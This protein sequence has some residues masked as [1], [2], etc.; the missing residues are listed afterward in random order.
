MKPSIMISRGTAVFVMGVSGVGKSTFA[1]RLAL[2]L[3]M[4]F[5]E[6]DRLHPA[7]NVRK[8]AAGIAL[9]DE[10]RWPW[11]DALAATVTAVRCQDGVVATCSAL[12]RSYRDR[13]RKVV[14]PP[15]LFVCLTADPVTLSE[16]LRLREH[17]FMSS[18]LLESQLNA[19][20]LPGSDEN[21]VVI[22]AEQSIE[23]MLET[24][25]ASE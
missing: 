17:H 14:A 18:T 4:E 22:S 7:S 19:L 1:E 2:K 5:I 6:G 15:L 23:D 24:I 21:A 11:L 8:M 20:E 16:R 12:K 25:R 9:N 3:K 13:L 10:D